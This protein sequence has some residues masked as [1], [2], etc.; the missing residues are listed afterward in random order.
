MRFNSAT[1][2]GVA[3]AVLAAM[4]GCDASELAQPARDHR[5]VEE[6]GLA[7][8]PAAPAV[9]T[10]TAAERQAELSGLQRIEGRPLWADNNRF[11]AEQNAAYQFAQHGTALEA[12]DL[13]DFLAKAHRFVNSPPEGTLTLTRAN[14]DRLLYDP[15]SSLFGVARNDGAPRTVFRPAD[16]QAYW[17]QQ[18]RE[19]GGAS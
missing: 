11:S 2:A 1:W 5:S 10:R 19:N 18:V 15:G 12:A 16:G 3:A 17:A 6:A 9:A 8:A 4:A 14:G 13:D 7:P